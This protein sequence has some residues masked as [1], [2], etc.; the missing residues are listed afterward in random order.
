MAAKAIPETADITPMFFTIDTPSYFFFLITTVQAP[1]VRGHGRLTRLT[2]RCTHFRVGKNERNAKRNQYDRGSTNDML[3]P[4]REPSR[5]KAAYDA[6]CD[7]T[8]DLGASSS[9]K[10]N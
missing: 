10:F 1:M 6:A 4:L 2:I 7:K 3:L 8:T 9:I 5:L